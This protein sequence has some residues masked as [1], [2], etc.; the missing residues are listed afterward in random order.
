MVPFE[1]AIDREKAGDFG[2]KF[3]ELARS[4]YDNNDRRAAIK[5]QIN[6]LLG[7]KLIE[8]KSYAGQ[9]FPACDFR[10]ENTLV[11]ISHFANSSRIMLP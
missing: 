1:S 9:Q 4:V 10:L 8:E 2:P 7:S 11:L 6:V 5:P 3:V